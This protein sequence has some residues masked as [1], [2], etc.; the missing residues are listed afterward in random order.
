[1][2]PLWGSGSSSIRWSGEAD[3]SKG[4]INL[5]HTESPRKS[6]CIDFSHAVLPR[7]ISE[8]KNDE[9]R[10]LGLEALGLQVSFSASFNWSCPRCLLVLICVEV[11]KG[12]LSR[13][14]W[15]NKWTRL[16]ECILCLW[17][18]STEGLEE[19]SLK[20]WVGKGEH[21]KQRQPH[22]PRCCTFQPM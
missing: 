15:L 11:S 10:A 12:G 22:H 20:G 5:W 6:A 13:S 14:P 19:L 17:E 21:S 8:T 7:V 2:V 1:M 4:P 16:P 9:I 18:G 3:Y